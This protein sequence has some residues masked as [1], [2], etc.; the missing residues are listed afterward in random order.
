MAD[1]GDYLS[2]I[3]C[4]IIKKTVWE[5]RNKEEYYGSFFVHVGVIFQSTPAEDTLV[6]AEPLISIRMEMRCG[7]K[8]IL[9][10]GCLSG[11]SLF[12]L[13]KIIPLTLSERFVLENL[14][15]N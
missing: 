15:V 11:Q 3:G 7:S 13:S 8:G 4:V 12:G 9:R 2:F 1:V 14:G 6:I 5:A 10:F